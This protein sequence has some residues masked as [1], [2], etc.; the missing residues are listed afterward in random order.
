MALNSSLNTTERICTKCRK[1][2]P[3]R[4]ALTGRLNFYND[5]RMCKPCVI[6][7]NNEYRKTEAGKR[8]RDKAQVKQWAKGRLPKWMRD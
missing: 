5:Q 1:E 8:A 4:N 6:V 3:L 7:H 2:L